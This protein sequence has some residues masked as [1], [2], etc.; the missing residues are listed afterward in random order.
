MPFT[1]LHLGPG[2]AVKSLSG[3]HISLVMFGLAQLAI[4]IEPGIR[5][6]QGSK[7]LHSGW[8]HTYLG[9]TVIGSLLLIFGR[10]FCLLIL[11]QW[12]RGLRYYGLN[13]LTSPDTISWVTAATG[14]F[15]GTYSH[16]FLDSFMHSDMRPF[17][18]FSN[19]NGLLSLIAAQTLEIGCIIAGIAGLLIWLVQYALPEWRK[20]HG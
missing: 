20:R 14:A 3:N 4:D 5:L 9:A 17:A 7:S 2:L 13:W 6:I 18:P 8:S 19:T 15:V 16:V 12:N 1:P 10:P 11:R